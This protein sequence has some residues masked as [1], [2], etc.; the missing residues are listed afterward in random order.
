MQNFTQLRYIYI[1][2]D[3]NITSYNPPPPIY[4]YIYNLHLCTNTQLSLTLKKKGLIR[5]NVECDATERA[6]KWKSTTN[7]VRVGVVKCVLLVVIRE[8]ESEKMFGYVYSHIGV[9][10]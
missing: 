1:C 4:I 6:K 2:M 7:P 8:R 10:L 5:W 9:C 3:N